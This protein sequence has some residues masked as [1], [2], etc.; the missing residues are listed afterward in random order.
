M[1]GD[2]KGIIEDLIIQTAAR[3]LTV[4]KAVDQGVAMSARTQ[5]MDFVG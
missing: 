1:V 5:I 3:L 4:D 2:N